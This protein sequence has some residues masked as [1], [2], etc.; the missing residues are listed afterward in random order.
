MNRVTP[1]L[2]A[3]CLAF[4]CVLPAAEFT[5]EKE[6]DGV[7]FKIDGELFTKYITDP[8]V[9]DKP[10]FWPV[11]GPSGK[12]MTRAYPME[13]IE[14]EKQD[15]PHHRSLWFGSQ[16]MN[17]YD[18]WHEVM[19][20][21]T[22]KDKSGKAKLGTTANNEVIA[23]EAK[24]DHA[25]L[26][27]SSTYLN[28]DG[29]EMLQDR[30]KFVFSVDEATGSRIIDTEFVFQGTQ[31]EV[32]L[33]DAKDAGLSVRV[34]HSM[35]VDAK[36]GGVIINSDGETDKEAWGK[37]AKWVDFNGPVEGEKLGVAMLNHPS[38][39]RYP[40][41]WHVRTYGL[42]TANPF[43]LNS[44]DKEAE[45]GTVVLKK[46]ETLTLRHRIIFH[47]GDEK[48]AKIAE[49]FEAYAAEKF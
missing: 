45:D 46:G 1:S 36:E 8:E 17:G 28:N 39:F 31:D 6:K 12:R 24:G 19:S 34:A 2:L 7:V 11:M 10:Y 4:P 33:G 13:D 23:A 16:D 18:T 32:S 37:R 41:P 21:E 29:E 26:E 5:V 15:H 22:R 25:V 38:S 48:A 40:T 43:G 14:G 44:I 30:R 42:F 9:G 49:A 47:E 27:V 35:C 20:F 3:L